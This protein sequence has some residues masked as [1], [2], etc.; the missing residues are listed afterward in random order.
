MARLIATSAR[1]ETPTTLASPLTLLRRSI[2]SGRRSQTIACAAVSVLFV[3][4]GAASLSAQDATADSGPA[5]P[6]GNRI[7]A[8][9]P[10]ISVIDKLLAVVCH[11]DHR[12]GAAFHECGWKSP[13]DAAA[14]MQELVGS[15]DSA[16]SVL[17]A[18]DLDERGAAPYTEAEARGQ[19]RT[20]HGHTIP[21]IFASASDSLARRFRDTSWWGP[22]QRA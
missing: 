1:L 21:W 12:H 16:S 9:L 6:T 20:G 11:D 3:A 19:V 13:S 22:M 17:R 15:G 10:Q 2:T 5:A 7:S 18:V 14:A 4:V 8:G